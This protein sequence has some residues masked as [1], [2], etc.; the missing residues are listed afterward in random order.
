MEA[1]SELERKR[2]QKRKKRD[3]GRAKRRER[4]KT[5]EL[6]KAYF[7]ARSKRANERKVA[8]RK[9]RSRKK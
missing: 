5:P 4:L 7:E 2:A 1:V 8:F 6:A 9:K 3:E